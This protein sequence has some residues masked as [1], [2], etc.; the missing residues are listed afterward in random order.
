[1]QAERTEA[2]NACCPYRQTLCVILENVN[3]QEETYRILGERLITN[4]NSKKLV[5]WALMLVENGY[6]SEN[7]IILAGLYN[8]STEEIEKYF[9]KTIEDLKINTNKPDEELIEIYALQLVED[10]IAGRINPLNGLAL[11]QDVIQATDYSNRFVQFYD[12]DE[13]LDYL[14]YEGKPLYNSGLNSNN[15]EE[16]VL[17]EFKIFLEMENLQIESDIREKSYCPKCG[18]FEKAILKTKY[19]FRKP[20]KYQIWVCGNCGSAK[21]E[22]FS[23]QI[24]KRKLIDRIKNNTQHTV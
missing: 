19:Q 1:M 13:D 21:L 17:E 3:I 23:S 2:R 15:K 4:F 16:F 22:H 7:L 18:Q 5:D 6:E 14:Q 11:M 9:W 12:L 24:V 10:V 8:D 20:F